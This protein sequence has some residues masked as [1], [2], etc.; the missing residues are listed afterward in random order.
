MEK[1][2]IFD[3]LIFI[4]LF[5]ANIKIEDYNYYFQLI[6]FSIIL[7]N[8]YA[9]FYIIKS[10]LKSEQYKIIYSVLFSLLLYYFTYYLICDTNPKFYI[11]VYYIFY[12]NFFKAVLIVFIHTYIVSK[13]SVGCDLQKLQNKIN[14]DIIPLSHVP[15]PQNTK[16][17][18]NQT[19]EKRNYYF[20]CSYANYFWHN[21]QHFLIFI[22]FLIIMII[23]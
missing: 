16:N 2:F 23:I 3:N 1:S 4:L 6:Y 18:E 5:V 17:E 14:C 9:L 11:I 15:I 8:I 21:K 12:P 22:L 19:S 20:L 13:L 10:N 7:H